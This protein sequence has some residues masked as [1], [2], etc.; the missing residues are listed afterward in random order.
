M[1]YTMR[2]EMLNERR[3]D[4]HLFKQGS[5]AVLSVVVCRDAMITWHT[6]WRAASSPSVQLPAHRQ[7]FGKP[8]G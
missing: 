5:A 2:L 6:L 3:R 8:T 4:W 1:T 7:V